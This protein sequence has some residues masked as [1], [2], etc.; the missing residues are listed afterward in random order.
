MRRDWLKD[1]R[2]KAGKSAADV[3]SALGLGSSTSV[4]HWET[5]ERTPSRRTQFKIAEVLK[6]ASIP[7]RF[8]QEIHNGMFAQNEQTTC[9]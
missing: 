9:A 6:D 8:D 4:N 2:I 7:R 3:A 5:G 1:A